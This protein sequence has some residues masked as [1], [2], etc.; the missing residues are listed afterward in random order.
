M[1]GRRRWFL[2]PLFILSDLGG[3][4]SGVFMG[5]VPPGLVKSLS[6]PHTDFSKNT[7]HFYSEMAELRSPIFTL[8]IAE[9]SQ[10]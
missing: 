4:G 8:E 9:G 2:C 6:L 5:V 1:G 10:E 7:P 3:G